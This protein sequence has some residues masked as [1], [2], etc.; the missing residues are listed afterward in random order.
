ML[1]IRSDALLS[2]VGF[3]RYFLRTC[4]TFNASWNGKLFAWQR[5][6]M[7]RKRGQS[8]RSFWI[9]FWRN[10]NGQSYFLFI[11]LLFPSFSQQVFQWKTFAEWLAWPNFWVLSIFWSETCLRIFWRVWQWQGWVF[12]IRDWSINFWLLSQY[13]GQF[14]TIFSSFRERVPFLRGFWF[15]DNFPS[16]RWWGLW[17][18]FGWCCCICEEEC[19]GFIQFIGRGFTVID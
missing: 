8:Y 16:L 6:M 7:L 15:D 17:G 4:W 1:F 11:P 5:V 12:R 10:L 13:L 19:H 3:W 18:R 9:I 2:F 14:F